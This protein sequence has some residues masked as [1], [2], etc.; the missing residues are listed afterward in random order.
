MA[1]VLEITRASREIAG[2]RGGRHRASCAHI[3]KLRAH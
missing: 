3:S 2:F 1:G